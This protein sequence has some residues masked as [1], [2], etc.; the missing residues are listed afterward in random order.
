VSCFQLVNG[1]DDHYQITRQSMMIKFRFIH[2]RAYEDNGPT[3]NYSDIRLII[4]I[5]TFVTFLL[6]CNDAV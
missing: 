5:F 1:D 3:V 2:F 6:S 4:S